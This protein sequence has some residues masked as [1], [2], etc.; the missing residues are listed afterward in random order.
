LVLCLFLGFIG[1][2]YIGRSGDKE[3]MILNTLGVVFVLGIPSSLYS[4]FTRGAIKK[5]MADVKPITTHPTNNER[6]FYFIF[7]SVIF[8]SLVVAS[9]ACIVH[10]DLNNELSVAWVID[11]LPNFDL[12]V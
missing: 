12:E 3:A 2:I 6:L 4:V 10:M 11:V 1:A 9:S 8:P 5:K 7:T